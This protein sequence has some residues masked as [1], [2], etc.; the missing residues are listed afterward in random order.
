MFQ[1][2]KRGRPVAVKMVDFQMTRLGHPMEDL[3]Y[4]FY[5]ST[6]HELREQ[7]LLGLL[8]HYFDI[9]CQKLNILDVQLDFTWEEFLSE[10]KKRSI[11]SGLFSGM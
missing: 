5:T 6:L 11:M 9:L 1:Y 8:R 4:F 3:L 7:H 2:N 10:Y